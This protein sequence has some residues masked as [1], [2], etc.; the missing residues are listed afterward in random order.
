MISFTYPAPLVNL[1]KINMPMLT[2]PANKAPDKSV[3]VADCRVVN[4]RLCRVKGSVRTTAIAA[5][6]PHLSAKKL[7]VKV[8]RKPPTW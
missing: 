1:K 3:T 5:R 2:D 8:A 7:I 6:L 4:E